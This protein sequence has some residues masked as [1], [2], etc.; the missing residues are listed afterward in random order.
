M[1]LGSQVALIKPNTIAHHIYGDEVNER[2]RHRYEVNNKYLDQ[3]EAAGIIFSSKTKADNLCEIVELPKSIHPWFFA[4]QFHPEFTSNP[5]DSHPL[6]LDYI[7]HIL[8]YKKET[9]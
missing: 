7:K 4:C 2:H 3:L 8:E 6:F 1:R 9:A 5:K